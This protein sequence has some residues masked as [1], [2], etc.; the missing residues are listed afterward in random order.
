M[1]LIIDT[2][3]IIAGLI[4]NGFSRKIILESA[5]EFFSPEITNEEILKYKEEIL[6][7]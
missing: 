7:K 5:I 6:E 3:R 4:K 1:K 2:N